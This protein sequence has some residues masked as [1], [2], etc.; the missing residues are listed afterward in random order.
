MLKHVVTE[1]T[2][3]AAAVPGYT[4]AGKTG[5]AQVA[6]PNGLGYAKGRYISSFIGYLPADNAQLLI[7]VKLDQ[8]SNA[9]FGGVVAAPTFST[10]AQFSCDHLKIAPTNAQSVVVSSTPLP[11]GAATST[12]LKKPSK[13]AKTTPGK[14]G[15]KKKTATGA[16]SEAVTKDDSSKAEKP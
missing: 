6:L 11:S 5:T 2:G 10:L 3:K 16:A 9:I 8:P 15:S 4:V 7:E 13:P 12:A 14:G 1:G